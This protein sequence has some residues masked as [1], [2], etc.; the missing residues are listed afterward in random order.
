MKN[1]IEVIK[2]LESTSGSNAKIQIIEENKSD[3]LFR[4]LLN[5]TYSDNKQYGFSHKKLTELVVREDFDRTEYAWKDGF[6]MLDT[7]AESNRN[8]ELTNKVLSF[9]ADC[10][11]EEKELWIRAIT[12]DLRCKISSKTINK[13]IPNLI[14]EW[15]VQGGKSYRQVKL[16][17]D[18]WIAISLK[19]NGVR[20]TVYDGK[21]K[22]RQNKDMKGLNHI[23]RQLD[24][25]FSLDQ[26]VID[27]EVIRK[28]VDNI[29]DEENFRL[30]TGLV[31]QDTTEDKEEL[32]FVIFDVIP[33]LEFDEGG[34]FLKAKERVNRLIE[35][36]EFL[37]KYKSLYPNVDVAPI[38]YT[39]T[40]HSMIEKLLDE[41]CEKGLEGIM[42]LRDTP[43]KRKKHTGILKGK[44]FETGDF[45]IVGYEEGQKEIAG[46]LGA[47]VVEYKGNTVKVGSG[48]KKQERIDFWNNRDSYIGKIIEVCYR[49]ETKDEKT[50]LPSLQHPTFKGIREDKDKP[51]Y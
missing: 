36:N 37:Q 14:F 51:S 19:L 47:F 4:K 44:A 16:K 24:E 34:S 38:L 10:E 33:K 42:I 25:L 11:A 7:L 49:V 21:F 20:G 6:E 30:T 29:P 22:S 13:A 8:N 27:G 39:G 9:L 5:Y 3:I 23:I 28:N 46:Q 32:E 35:F 12:K 40:D 1:S 45:R 41:V 15:S 26:F 31:N 43:Y 2:K 48:Y 18:E 50:G 17:K